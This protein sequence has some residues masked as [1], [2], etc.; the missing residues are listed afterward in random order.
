MKIK[1]GFCMK[2]SLSCSA[3]NCIHNANGL[4]SANKINV[5]GFSASTSP[6]TDCK[7]FDEKSFTSAYSSFSNMNFTGEFKQLFNKNG[8]EL[9][10]E[11]ACEAENCQFNSSHI[12]N[13]ENVQIYGPGANSSVGTQC[14][15]FIVR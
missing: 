2:T 1:E 4:C 8:I 11:I 14:E 12:C 13:A 3:A 9:K 5:E 15:T 6:G 10:P 7:T